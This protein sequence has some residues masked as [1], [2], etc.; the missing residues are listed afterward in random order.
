MINAIIIDDERHSCDALK[1]LLDKCC[2]QVQVTAMCYS[3][4]EGIKKINELKPQLVFLD[5][6]MPHM[7]G[8]QMLEQ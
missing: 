4:E 5:I 7:N 3:A 2:P 6:E 1:M 8:F